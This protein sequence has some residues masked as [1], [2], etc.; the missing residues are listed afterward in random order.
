MSKLI[1]NVTKEA[2]NVTTV[3][4]YEILTFYTCAKT[5]E[6]IGKPEISFFIL[7]HNLF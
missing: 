5:I 4:W 3:S 2:Q 1:T 6:N 7:Y